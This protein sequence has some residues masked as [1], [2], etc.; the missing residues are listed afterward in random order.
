MDIAVFVG[1]AASGPIDVPVAVEDAAQ[2]ALIFGADAPLAWDAKHGEQAYALLGP[3]VRAFF[4]NGGRR[5]WVVR[6]ANTHDAKANTF[7]VPGLGAIDVHNTLA[8][9]VLRARSEGSWS[10]G[11]RVSS[12]LEPSPVRLE[13]RSLTPLVL[14]GL[15][16]SSSDL[17]PGDLVRVS[18]AGSAWTLLFV[19]SSIE[20]AEASPPQ[21]PT[22]DPPLRPVTVTGEQPWWVRLTTLPSGRHGHLHY[23]GAHGVMH[24]AAA[25]VADA[26]PGDEGLIRIGL[27]AGTT[28]PPQ[29]GSLVRGVF[30]SSTVWI[31][32]TE[33]D[34]AADSSTAVV[35]TPLQVTTHAP[36]HPPVQAP[37]ALVER[38]TLR[39]LLQDAA[40]STSVL[41]GLGFAPAHP[42]FVGALPTDKALY[43]D[44]AAPVAPDPLSPADRVTPPDPGTF[45]A[46]AAQPRFALAGPTHAPLLFLPLGVSILTGPALPAIRPAG[47]NRLRDGLEQ[48]DPALF[49]DKD[50]ATIEEERLLAESIWIRDQQPSAR[51]LNGM[52]A[53]LSVDEVTVVAVP[54]AVQRDWYLYPGAHIPDAKSPEQAVQPDWSK[55][56][57]CATHVPATPVLRQI[58]DE[59][60]GAFT[61][62]WSP[63]DVADAAY[64]LQETIDAGRRLRRRDSLLRVGTF[65]S[66]SSGGR[67]GRRSTTASAPSLPGLQAAGRTGSSSARRRRRAGC[68]TTPR[69]TAQPARFSPVQ[70]ALLRMC[71]ARGDIFGVLAL[72]EHYRERTAIAHVQALKAWSGRPRGS[73]PDPLFSY[74]ACYHPW[75]FTADPSDPT[76]IRRTPPDGAAAGIIALRSSRARRLDRAGERA[77]EGCPAARP[78]AR[79]RL[80]PGTAGRAG[81]RRP[82][83]SRRLPLAR[84]GHAVRRRR[85]ASD[86]RSATAA[87]AAPGGAAPRRALCV[88]A[89]QRRCFG[90]ACSAA[91][92][93]CS[94]GHTRSEPS[95]AR[96]PP[97]RIA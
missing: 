86:R 13:V 45:A 3:A 82:A 9:A 46:A 67:A 34:V 96:P 1:F 65:S 95:R 39:L 77:A 16:A 74:G 29:P 68:S 24:T 21:A 91:S 90:A 94:R 64:E 17:V 66:P 4:R 47:L 25:T 23:L 75:F 57:D 38:L 7:A 76:A 54:D 10:D 20:T 27:E 32:V 60:A 53:L 69:S 18:F 49:L 8:P 51:T 70:L 85:P 71:A 35:G 26:V 63:T 36:A 14:D 12:S 2:F 15:V 72:P 56:L 62:A 5:C 31:D 88:R 37:D 43:T 44:P 93:S 11:L 41:S 50:L 42:R 30:S 59:E 28:N 22:G 87:D 84:G 6:V 78:A 48:L 73:E 89:E 52:H 55:F 61:L 40:D 83:R 97:T 19:V 92:S 33:V 81:E 79:R 80:V 58:G